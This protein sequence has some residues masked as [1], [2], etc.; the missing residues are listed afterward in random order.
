[1]SITKLLGCIFRRTPTWRKKWFTE[2]SA[3]ER[4]RL[5]EEWY[6]RQE[7]GKSVTPL[8][9]Q[10]IPRVKPPPPPPGRGNR[11]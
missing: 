3:V 7:I 10:S 8:L 5:F 11:A 4:R 1:M 2:W 6:A 9:P